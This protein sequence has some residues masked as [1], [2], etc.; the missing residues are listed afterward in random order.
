MLLM[1]TYI[2]NWVEPAALVNRYESELQLRYDGS[3]T[4][5]PNHWL[6]AEELEYAKTE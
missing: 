5:G 1:D 4:Q 2:C 3:V 6:V